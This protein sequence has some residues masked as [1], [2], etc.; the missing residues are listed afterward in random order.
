M[1]F[2]QMEIGKTVPGTFVKIQ[3]NLNL[4]IA[5]TKNSYMWRCNACNKFFSKKT[6]ENT[7]D[8]DFG[9]CP[10]CRSFYFM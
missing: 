4:K 8:R 9:E 7:P 2:I 10:H 6:I 1:K 3:S 5:K